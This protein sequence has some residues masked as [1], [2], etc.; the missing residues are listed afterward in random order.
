MKIRSRLDQITLVWLK[1]TYSAAGYSSG[2]GC[3]TSCTNMTRFLIKQFEHILNTEQK[4][5]NY[6][7][8]SN[9]IIYR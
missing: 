8:L 3:I 6:Y 4:P 9:E 2:S 1:H 5:K 7:F